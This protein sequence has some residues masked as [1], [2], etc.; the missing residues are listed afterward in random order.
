MRRVLSY[1]YALRFDQSLS[2]YQSW[3]EEGYAGTFSDLL[4]WILWVPGEI[5]A[6]KPRESGELQT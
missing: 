1:R 3:H 6:F 5:P 4:D 2:P